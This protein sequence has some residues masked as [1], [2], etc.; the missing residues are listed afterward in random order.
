[1]RY[2]LNEE[3]TFLK[4]IVVDIIIL[5]GISISTYFAGFIIEEPVPDKELEKTQTVEYNEII[6]QPDCED[7]QKES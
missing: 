1:M 3:W 6:E 5:V 2:F 7:W 4:E